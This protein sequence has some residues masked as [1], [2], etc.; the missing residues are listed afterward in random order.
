MATTRKPKRAKGKATLAKSGAVRTDGDDL[1][2]AEKAALK[3]KIRAYAW[4]IYENHCDHRVSFGIFEKFLE[5]TIFHAVDK[6][7]V[8][9]WGS[10]QKAYVR[11]H[12]ECIACRYH[13]SDDKGNEVF[14]DLTDEYLKAAKKEALKALARLKGMSQLNASGERD[15]AKLVAVYCD[16]YE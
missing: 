8:K 5:K 1:T 2:H 9:E 15:V 14:E 7:N 10:A 16:G 4:E 12:I 3:D 13:R 11:P 6:D